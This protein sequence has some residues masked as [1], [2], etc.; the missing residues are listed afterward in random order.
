MARPT[1]PRPLGGYLSDRQLAELRAMLEEQREFRV[2]QLRDLRDPT[3]PL[4][5]SD[6]DI[7]RSLMSAAGEALRDIE[8]ALARMDA[9]RYGSCV[10]CG[11]PV[12]IERLE[13]LPQVARCMACQRR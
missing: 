5:G 11:G 13:I 3:A 9:G 6:P 8:D 2:D 12:E 10:A 4:G 1:L 7:T